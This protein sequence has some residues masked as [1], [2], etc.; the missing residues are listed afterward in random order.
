MHAAKLLR[1][2]MRSWR[3]HSP[4]WGVVRDERKR[5]ER[6]EKTR[7]SEEG[8]D[9]CGESAR[10]STRC[11]HTGASQGIDAVSPAALR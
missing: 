6:K 2:L 4:A 3:A 9:M 8:R 10:H 1:Q 11:M 5:R 7:A